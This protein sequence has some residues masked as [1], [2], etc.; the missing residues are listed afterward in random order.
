[1]GS[2]FHLSEYH[3]DYP[4]TVKRDVNSGYIHGIREIKDQVTR[5]FHG[6][7]QFDWVR[8]RKTWLDVTCPVYIDIDNDILARLETYD[9]SGLECIFI[10]SKK[11]FTQGAMIANDARAVVSS[12]I[13][14]QRMFG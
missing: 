11:R 8:P 10:V 3:E 9:E 1:M 6:H 13:Y 2:I 7:C 12:D 14:S 4:D 5:E